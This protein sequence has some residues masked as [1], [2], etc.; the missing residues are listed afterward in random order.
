M[1]K[2]IIVGIALEARRGFE[3]ASKSEAG[4]LLV[5][6]EETFSKAEYDSARDTLFSK[7]DV[8]RIVLSNIGIENDKV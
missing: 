2:L 8:V 4:E 1:L 7:A 5:R 3:V 6:I